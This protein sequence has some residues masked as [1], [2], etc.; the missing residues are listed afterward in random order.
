MVVFGGTASGGQVFGDGAKYDPQTDTWTAISTTNAP[1]ARHSHKALWVSD[2]MYVWGGYGKTG[3]AVQGGIYDPLTDSWSKMSINGQPSGRTKFS[4]VWDS[5][6]QKLIV[7]GGINGINVQASG[8]VYDLVTDSWT[9][10]PSQGA[11]TKRL[12]HMAVWV[13]PKVGMPNGYMAVFGGTDTF[14][15]FRDGALFDPVNNTWLAIN[16]QPGTQG[17]APPPQALESSSAVRY[18]DSMFLWGGWDGGTYYAGGHFLRPSVKPGGYWYTINNQGAPAG[19]AG[20]VSLYPDFY[21]IFVWGGCG[22]QACSTVYADGGVWTQGPGGGKW[23]N[24][25]ADP[26]LSARR[27]TAAVWTGQEAIVWGGITGTTPL[28]DGARRRVQAATF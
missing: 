1:E 9:A 18:G 26:A 5:S 14:D 2:K 13:L 17:G 22:G 7:F 16:N 12:A 24:F 27:D 8:G 6:H 21:G 11:P 10:T 28:G 23:E 4:M 19:R 3:Y 25:P 20:H 15:W